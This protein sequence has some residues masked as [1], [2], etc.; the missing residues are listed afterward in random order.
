MARKIFFLSC[1]VLIH[2]I[3]IA[4]NATPAKMF[5]LVG[6]QQSG[7]DFRNDILETPQLFYYTYEYLYNGGGVSIGDI[8]NDGL[9]DIYFSST[10]GSNKLYL[11]LGNLKFKDITVSAGVTG[12]PG[13]KTGINMIDI[14]NDGWLDIY[15]CK[16]GISSEKDRQNILYINNHNQT[17]TDRSSEWGLN[18]PGYSTQSYFFDFDKDGD[19]DVY[20]A[21]HPGDFANAMRLQGRMINGRQVLIEDSTSKYIGGH[22]FQNT[23]NRFTDITKKANLHHHAYNLSVVINDFNNDGWPDIYVANDYVKPDFLY[24][25]NKN[26]TFTEKLKDHFSHISITSMGSDMNDLNNDG[27]E[28]L[29]VVDMAIEDPARQKQLF[30]HNNQYDEFSLLLRLNLYYQ[31]AHNVLQL[32]NGNGKFSDVAYY[33]NTAETDWSWGTLIA[34]YDND[35]WK[36]IYVANGYKR[37]MTD[38]DYKMFVLDSVKKIMARG[39]SVDLAGWFNQIPQVRIQNYFYHNNGSLRFDNYSSQWSDATPSFSNGIAYGDLDND[40]DLDMVVNNID[41]EAFLLKNNISENGQSK[42]LRFRFFSDPQ[43]KKEIYGA[44]VKLF[45]GKGNIQFQ[46]YDPQRGFISSVEHFLHFGTGTNAVVPKVEISFPSGKQLVMENVKTGQTLNVYETEG[47]TTAGKSVV[48]TLFSESSG[49]KKFNYLHRENDF[50]DFKREPLIPYRCSRK[51]PYYT[52]A[53]VNGDGREDIFIGGSAGNEGRLMMQNADGSFGEKKQNAFTADKNFEDAGV[54]FFDA[55]GDGDKDLY[56]ASGGSEFNPGNNLYQD[57]L[58]LN[59]SKGNFKR[60]ATSLPKETYNGSFVMPFDFDGDGDLDLFVGGGVLPGKFPKHDKSLLLQNNKG[61]FTEVTEKFIPQIDKLR[62]VNYSA[63]ANVDKDS[64]S[65]LII[66]GE[67]QPVSIFKWVNERF[68]LIDLPVTIRPEGKKQQN[69]LLSEI[70]GWWNVVRIEDIDNDG[71]DDI[72]V[73]NRGMNSRITAGFNEPCTIYAKD[74]D[75]NG[76][77]DAVLGFYTW[78]KLYPMFHRDA[79]IDQMPSMR[80]KFIRYHQYAGKTLG[81][82][83]TPEQKKDMDVYKANCFESGVFLNEGQS[84]LRFE[85]FPQMAQLSSINDLFIADLDKDGMK[86]ILVCGNSYDPDITTGNLDAMASLFLKGDGKGGFHAVSSSS[87]GLPVHGEIRRIIPLG[88]SSF[89]FLQ[90]NAAAMIYSIH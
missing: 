33:S 85:P 21:G 90:N 12:G 24:I 53:D 70:T 74:F 88:N 72:F 66:A 32:N 40:G 84:G 89:I 60:S 18:Y 27:F 51:G 3:A 7:I 65:E 47:K 49:Q 2:V 52:K 54:L 76:S 78:G 17:F 9:Q 81:E 61:V 68:M 16:A 13:T 36:D 45:D 87:S 75:S 63:W 19:M 50:I 39:Q 30:V 59:D 28:D 38:W 43:S 26:G 71:D 82:I 86:D 44:T 77:Y 25:N 35:G 56:I 20:I 8:N 42:F 14:N 41:D 62:I 57:R 22:L 46:R 10:L 58:Y 80:K 79:L 37:D 11:N 55:D 34:D 83:F 67:W 69:A 48:K 29:F 5:S 4:Q 73:G 15:V 31:Y 64:N 6:S 23:G 1:V